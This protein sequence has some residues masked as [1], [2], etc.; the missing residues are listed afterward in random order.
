MTNQ[1]KPTDSLFFLREFK[2]DPYPGFSLITLSIVA[3]VSLLRLLIF[4][5]HVY[6]HVRGYIGI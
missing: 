4:V 1:S 3:L 5:D 6:L 2:M